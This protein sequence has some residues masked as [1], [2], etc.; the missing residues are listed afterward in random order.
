MIAFDIG[1]TRSAVCP[2]VCPHM[3]S[4][5]SPEPV[6]LYANS[7]TGHGP[8]AMAHEPM[9]SPQFFPIPPEIFA[10]ACGTVSSRVSQLPFLRS[11]VM[12][13]GELVGV[14]ME[15][16]NAVPAKSLPLTMPAGPKG[17]RGEGL[18]RCIE[19]RLHIPG[20]TSA[21]VIADVLTGAG[22]AEPALIPDRSARR[23][24][25]G[26][27][28][29]SPF[30]WHIASVTAPSIRLGGSVGG[31]D[32]L[33][34]LDICPVCLT[35][36]LARVSGKQLF[37]IPRT[38]FYIGCSSCGAKFIPVGPAF[39]L[40]SIAT[41]RDPLW[42]RHLDKTHTPQEWE[43]LARGPGQAGT[44]KRA[45]AENTAGSPAPAPAGTL[46][47]QKDGSVAVPA[48]DRTLYFRPVSL[49][50]PGPVKK[51]T[52]ARVQ[53]TLAELLADPAFGHLRGPVS[54]KY[55]R[56]LPLKAGIFLSQLKER[57]D[58]F[59]REFLNPYGDEKYGAVLVADPGGT[60]RKGVLLVVT[61]RRIS[62]AADCSGSIRS[63]VNERFGRVGPED[64]LLN[65][66]SLRCRIN[67]LLCTCR[68]EAGL[69]AHA[70]EKEEDRQSILT[71]L[72]GHITGQ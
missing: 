65:G 47:V 43:A 3:V 14:A 34:W 67:T 40:V 32:T 50:F 22:I 41:I 49:Q 17:E 48:G 8:N 53:K 63:T 62:H 56:Y 28:L 64:C 26:I 16:L 5:V 44:R 35:G 21:P 45:G 33:S 37:G 25:R 51:G 61:G 29:V 70:A 36:I 9:S 13:T 59:Y 60:E 19:E 66:D 38:D 54:A 58:M 4:S 1:A 46:A 55:S 57:Q 7:Y 18:G 39:R 12:V 71:A 68:R 42:K 23:E 72:A 10:R 30:T 15:C 31:D 69:Y 52:F 24:R 6:S 11:G 20:N 2:A 27:R